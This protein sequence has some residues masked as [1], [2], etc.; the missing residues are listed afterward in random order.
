M[1]KTLQQL[2]ARLVRL[3]KEFAEFKAAL[4][5]KQNTPWYRRIVGD[6]AGDQDFAEIVRLGRNIRSGKVKG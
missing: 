1:S 6:F 5:E 2:E 3:E 4:T